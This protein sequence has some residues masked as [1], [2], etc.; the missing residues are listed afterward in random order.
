M[1][2]IL[3]GV[4][5]MKAKI[6]IDYQTP[7]QYNA[8]IERDESKMGYNSI[9]AGEEIDEKIIN[10]V[11][12]RPLITDLLENAPEWLEAEKKDEKKS[13]EDSKKL[14]KADERKKRKTELYTLNKDEQVK[15]LENFG[16]SAS[17]INKLRYEKDRVN[18][19][20][21]LEFK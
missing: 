7:E 2:I 18:K 15:R 14:K 3:H 16:L 20:L 21:E 17:E 19:L 1:G 4:I 6:Q 9:L 11:T 13:S 5:R 8:H 10:G 12:K